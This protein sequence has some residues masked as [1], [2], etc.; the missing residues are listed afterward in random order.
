[1]IRRLQDPLAG[2]S[3]GTAASVTSFKNRVSPHTIALGTLRCFLYK[4]K[5][6][7]AYHL[8]DFIRSDRPLFAYTPF[9]PRRA[10]LG[11]PFVA[12]DPSPVAPGR[13]RRHPASVRGTTVSVSNTTPVRRPT[14]ATP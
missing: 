11:W 14:G 6:N 8:C 1:M 5:D 10:G 2:A 9:G 3:G 12:I 13:Q 4:V 7:Y